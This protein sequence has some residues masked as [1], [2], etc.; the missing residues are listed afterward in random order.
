MSTE[1]QGADLTMVDD[2]GAQGRSKQ[3]SLRSRRTA[4]VG[5]VSVVAVIVIIGG[6]AAIA[7]ANN[8]P[9]AAS[10]KYVHARD[11]NASA[12]GTGELITMGAPD[13]VSVGEKYTQ[14]ITFAPGYESW[15]DKT[16]AFQTDLRGGAPPGQGFIP[17]SALRWQV[18]ESAVCSWL[19]YYVDS[20]ATGDTA[21]SA[22]A[23]AQITSASSWP[24]ITGLNYPSGLGSTVA[25]INAGDGKLVQALIDT[26]RGPGNCAAVGPFPPA[27]MSNA[28]VREKLVAASQAGE[29]EL[30]SDPMA[31][32]LGISATP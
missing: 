24:A 29:R 3:R 15:R 6:L 12:T 25:A 13:D 30:A 7:G 5:I 19:N 8:P 21:A 2:Q 27:G 31:Q 16:I 14:D 32:K 10:G 1:K 11:A 28:I 23:A 17:S 9:S 20:Q 4:K 22:S 26:G 18:A